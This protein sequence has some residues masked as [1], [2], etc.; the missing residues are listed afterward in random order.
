MNSNHSY[1]DARS[2]IKIHLLVL[3]FLHPSLYRLWFQE[4]LGVQGCLMG[5][6]DQVGQLPA[7][8]IKLNI[9]R[10]TWSKIWS[11]SKFTY[12]SSTLISNKGFKILKLKFTVF[13]NFYKY[14]LI[15]Q[16]YELLEWHCWLEYI[17]LCCRCEFFST[18]HSYHCGVK[19]QTKVLSQAR[20]ADNVL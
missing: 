14:V 18:G 8:R 17:N 3:L 2:F 1:S 5:P 4:A 7:Q 10:S 13:W 16:L 20:I 6:G 9:F 19:W 12:C 11:F 15:K